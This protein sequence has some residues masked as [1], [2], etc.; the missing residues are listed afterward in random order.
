MN[1]FSVIGNVVRSA[2]ALHVL[3]EQ[4]KRNT[5]TAKELHKVL[6]DLELDVSFHEAATKRSLEQTLPQKIFKSIVADLELV[7][8]DVDYLITVY[9]QTAKPLMKAKELQERLERSIT[10]VRDIRNSLERLGLTTNIINFLHTIID[11]VNDL[12]NI[13]KSNKKTLNELDCKTAEHANVLIEVA[14]TLKSRMDGNVEERK[15][16]IRQRGS[17]SS[18][19]P[20]SDLIASS[21]IDDDNEEQEMNLLAKLP[22]AVKYLNTKISTGGYQFQSQISFVEQISKV[23]TCWQIN[24]SSIEYEEDE[25]NNKV[26]L[27]RGASGEVFAGLY[28]TICGIK[29]PVAVKSI[30]IERGVVPEV[31]RE[32]FLH[33]TVQHESVLHLF[34]MCYPKKG[35]GNILIVLERMSYSLKHA[36]EEKRPF[37]V[38]MV[39]RDVASA[40]SHLHD[41][42]V[43]HRDIKP[44]NILLTD[45]GKRA[46]VSD[47]GCSRRQFENS[48]TVG[49]IA[50]GT[51]MYMPPEV[52]PQTM[53]KTRHSWD[54]WSFGILMCEV[55]CNG[56][57][58]SYMSSK[59]T[60][61]A[62]AACS[63]A[64]G[65]A[66]SQL[67]EL[68]LLCL[69][70]SPK[71]RVPMMKVYLN[72]NGTLPIEEIT[73]AS[74]T[75]QQYGIDEF[76]KDPT[77]ETN[78]HHHAGDAQTRHPHDDTDHTAGIIDEKG[79]GQITSTSDAST[80][81]NTISSYVLDVDRS[82]GSNGAHL[83]V[84]QQTGNR[85]S[86]HGL[87]T[88]T[89]FEHVVQ[90]SG[91]GGKVAYGLQK[92]SESLTGSA[93]GV[94]EEHGEVPSTKA[95]VV[96]TVTR[97]LQHIQGGV[98]SQ[99][100]GSNKLIKLCRV[101]VVVENRS[102]SP[103]TAFKVSCAGILRKIMDVPVIR[104][105]NYLDTPIG[106]VLTWRWDSLVA[107]VLKE[108]A[109]EL[110]RVIVDVFTSSRKRITITNNSISFRGNFDV[111]VNLKEDML[112]PVASVASGRPVQLSLS[113]GYKRGLSVNKLKGDG[114]EERFIEKGEFNSMWAGSADAGTILVFRRGR[115]FLCA[116][117]VPEV[118]CFSVIFTE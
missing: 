27:G 6:R 34:G 74:T 114:R 18:K 103:L 100:L 25:E 69:K 84:T 111:S 68:A 72:L 1:P 36:I 67:R 12:K 5:K 45:D 43:I 107:M 42:G 15:T 108:W 102:S 33:L 79:V 98:W 77:H 53:V 60:D 7:Q 35:A 95:R 13:C 14:D 32:V 22:D 73:A 64:A 62:G 41:H 76:F 54:T 29:I 10:K 117:F 93:I 31:L 11:T 57:R 81:Y 113:D 106:S 58:D 110:L 61:A 44:S 97:E 96:Y 88:G 71:D 37:D 92:T 70:A 4:K 86:L 47:F 30:F 23:W 83:N 87:T 17:G 90:S 55:L 50:L 28:E 51:F 115:C 80:T 3:I 21:S 16:M 105:N 116:V 19:L 40:I 101:N 89:P 38:R 39:L 20:K 9:K 109:T 94:T 46:K 99:F 2:Y 75:R 52:T 78:N 104:N 118:S 65:I 49:S 112:W 8:T 56:G 91:A 24:K 63:W 66:D 26:Q 85:K 59:A 82:D 48:M